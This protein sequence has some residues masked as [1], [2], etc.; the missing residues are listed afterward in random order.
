MKIIL[1][2]LLVTTSALAMADCYDPFGKEV[3]TIS[4][5]FLNQ[6]AMAS[7][8][9]DG[10]VAIVINEDNL[11]SFIK[12]LQKVI[13]YHECG[14]IALGHLLKGKIGLEEEQDADCYGIRAAL[15]LGEVTLS[16]LDK[17]QK[18]FEKLGPGDWQHLG[19]KQ[20]AVNIKKCLVDGLT[21]SKWVSCK[22]KYYDNI[23]LIEKSIPTMKA[24]AKVCASS[25]TADDCNQA[26]SLTK[27]LNDGIFKTISALDEEC[28]YVVDPKFSKDFSEF[29]K[30]KIQITEGGQK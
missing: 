2:L 7:K 21:E 4:A 18:G 6:A 19:G 17:I 11:S 9:P 26:K 25:P 3:P 27:T 28:P 30:L 12:P 22:K 5:S 16:D 10:K 29:Q 14:H 20:R 24:L 23:E 1:I 15:T 8:R 13:I